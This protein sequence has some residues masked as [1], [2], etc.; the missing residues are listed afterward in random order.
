MSRQD[1]I[2]NIKKKI[3]NILKK[4]K[5]KKAGIFGSYALGTYNKSSDIDILVEP[6]KDMG[7]E[8]VGL[9]LELEDRL[10]KKVDLITYKYISPYLKKEILE[11]EVRII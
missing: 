6:P 7:L 11:S 3:I 4:Y 1:Q 8:F 2:E 5:I 10:H 9:K